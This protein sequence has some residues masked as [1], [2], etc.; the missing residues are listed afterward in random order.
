MDGCRGADPSQLMEEAELHGVSVEL[1]NG[2]TGTNRSTVCAESRPSVLWGLYFNMADGSALQA[3]GH[4]LPSNV[5]VCSGP[6]GSLGHEHAIRQVRC[7]RACPPCVGPQCVGP[8]CGP[9]SV[10]PERS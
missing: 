7:H 1:F 5:H 2:D 3:E 6:D 4:D 8:Q 10:G 9:P